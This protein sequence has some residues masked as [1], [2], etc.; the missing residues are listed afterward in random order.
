MASNYSKYSNVRVYRRYCFGAIFSGLLSLCVAGAVAVLLLFP[1]VFFVQEGSDPAYLTGLQFVLY[2]VRNIP[3]L[4]FE[5][6]PEMLNYDK[7]VV[8]NDYLGAYAGDNMMLGVIKNIY[9]YVEYVLLAFLAIVVIFALTVGICGLVFIAAGRNHNPKM[10]LSFTKTV[11][12]FTIVFLALT[13]LYFFF[14]FEMIKAVVEAGAAPAELI[15]FGI[16]IKELTDFRY[17]TYPAF[18]PLLVVAALLVLLIAL[19]ITYNCAFKNKVFAGRKKG[20]KDVPPVEN[21][22]EQPQQYGQPQQMSYQQMNYQQAYGSGM[23][24]EPA[25]MKP[26]GQMGPMTLPIGLKEIGDHAYAKCLTLKDATIPGGITDLGPS[27]FSNCLNLETVTIP[28]TVKEIGYNCFF[29][30]PNLKKITYQGRVQDW[31]R[32]VKGSNWLTHSGTNIVDAVDGK[33][34]VNTQ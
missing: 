10:A 29:N 6:L 7:F 22:P 23:M 2:S 31:K 3:F 1:L 21:N 17:F 15:V 19:S 8:F 16:R 18:F 20:G 27:A 25:P 14:A 32:I 13:F 34:A 28:V 4:K 5:N 24:N 11:F 9:P 12:A 33:I 30:T 26:V